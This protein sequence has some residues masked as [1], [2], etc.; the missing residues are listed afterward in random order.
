MVMLGRLFTFRKIRFR[1]FQKSVQKLTQTMSKHIFY[2]ESSD[3]GYCITRSPNDDV[4][5]KM[6]Y[7]R[8][9]QP[10]RVYHQTEFEADFAQRNFHK[11]ISKSPYYWPK[12]TEWKYYI[13]RMNLGENAAKGRE[14]L[15]IVDWNNC[16]IFNRQEFQLG[17]T[18]SRLKRFTSEK[19]TIFRDIT[20]VPD[21]IYR[22][23]AISKLGIC[24]DTSFSPANERATEHNFVRDE[25]KLQASLINKFGNP[26]TNCFYPF[27]LN[28]SA[29]PFIP[30]NS[31]IVYSKPTPTE[32]KSNPKSTKIVSS[33]E[34]LKK[35]IDEHM[36]IRES[37]KKTVEQIQ[38][39]R[40]KNDSEFPELVKTENK[41]S[42][43]FS[44]PSEYSSAVSSSTSSLSRLNFQ[45]QTRTSSIEQLTE[46][47]V[48]HNRKRS[49]C[50]VSICFMIEFR[51]FLSSN[52][53]ISFPGLFIGFPFRLNYFSSC[54]DCYTS[55]IERF[56]ENRKFRRS[57]R[58]SNKQIKLE[59]V[60]DVDSENIVPVKPRIPANNGLSIPATAD[61]VPAQVIEVKLERIDTDS[62]G[63]NHFK[64]TSRSNN[65]DKHL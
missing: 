45:I 12:T 15:R 31:K 32:L 22:K 14:V 16:D 62:V 42:S 60:G 37:K 18:Q 38:K 54:R 6:I 64:S 34:K 61:H 10:K 53:F 48:N 25:P 29:S 20:E 55:E 58:E 13:F 52:Y 63:E 26:R 65:P 30:K 33:K 50:T 9:E 43:L 35:C 51:G 24:E 57:L 2:S 40:T 39:L 44:S 17:I 27:P 56:N 23:N 46:N 21:S 3:V 49:V 1:F 59:T 8:V 7:G 19:P 28:P 47:L 36:K 4:T 41:K 5:M 11:I